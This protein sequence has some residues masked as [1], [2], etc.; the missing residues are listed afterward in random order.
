M[1]LEYDD[2][3]TDN[4]IREDYDNLLETLVKEAGLTEEQAMTTIRI[5]TSICRCCFNRYD[6]RCCS[7]Y[8]I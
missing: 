2:Y 6:C 5:V 1:I 4:D 3:L 8:D 7:A